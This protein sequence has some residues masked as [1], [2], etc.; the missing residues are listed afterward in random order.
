MTKKT[1]NKTFTLVN[2]PKPINICNFA[3][4]I[5]MCVIWAARQVLTCGFPKIQNIALDSQ[6]TVLTEILYCTQTGNV[7]K[8]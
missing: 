8:K 5:G 7:M 6:H 4:Y 1:K 2:F 3:R